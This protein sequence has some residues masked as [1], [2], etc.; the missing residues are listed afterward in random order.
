MLL[1]N[2]IYTE[3]NANSRGTPQPPKGE[4]YYRQLISGILLT[5]EFKKIPNN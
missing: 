4:E 3:E 2:L 1:K 5:T